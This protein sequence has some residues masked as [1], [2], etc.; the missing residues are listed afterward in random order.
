ME[1]SITVDNKIVDNNIIDNNRHVIEITSKSFN[2]EYWQDDKF[3]TCKRIGN[4]L[5]IIVNRNTD[6]YSRDFGVS[7][8]NS[9]D[10][11]DIVYIQFTQS[12]VG[13]KFIPQESS[14][15]DIEIPTDCGDNED[16]CRYTLVRGGDNS[17]KCEYAALVKMDRV[18]VNGSVMTETE[19]GLNVNLRIEGG[20]QKAFIAGIYRYRIIIDK[21]TNIEKKERMGYDGGIRAS[22]VNGDDGN[23]SVIIE[24]N[25]RPFSDND[26]YFYEIRVAHYDNS[27]YYCNIKACY[28]DKGNNEIEIK[29]LGNKELLFDYSGK[30]IGT[31]T[32]E[33][34]TG[35]SED[36]DW[37]VKEVDYSEGENGWIS[38]SYYPLNVIV[39]CK[40]NIGEERKAKII[41]YIGEEA[42]DDNL[43]EVEVTQK[44]FENYRLDADEINIEF[45]ADDTVSTA[46]FTLVCYGAPLKDIEG[47]KKV[48]PSEK[49]ADVVLQCLS[50]F[51]SG[52]VYTYM[53][54]C[55]ANTR[56]L[57]SEDV[58]TIY[59]LELDSDKP[60]L[61]KC[62]VT[63]TQKKAGT[64][65]VPVRIS[66]SEIVGEHANIN[67]I[68]NPEDSVLTA[69]SS[70][71]WCQVSSPV[72]QAGNTFMSQVDINDE[73]VYGYT[74]KCKLVFTNV[75]EPGETASCVV[76]NETGKKIKITNIKPD[77]ST[78]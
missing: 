37:G 29:G 15:K 1:Y 19:P 31:D 25:G 8:Y 51:Q 38:L 47:G 70:S 73:N 53:F 13:Y 9:C 17:E 2:F 24:N 61:P 76:E 54:S 62:V 39:K 45:M 43:V 63:V 67:L 56:N 40:E 5:K 3:T 41:F 72:P 18:Y 27:K 33:I 12:G 68:A 20:T 57:E 55:Y 6:V 78:G 64:M 28:K 7:L 35:Q 11:T 52:L 4:V 44:T 50:Y 77:S 75:N 65:L 36:C 22:V 34:I 26:E 10:K 46:T 21:E 14:N 74:R 71:Q 42:V 59:T 60:N 49:K 23:C 58:Q 30:Y 69:Y 32:I 16:D 48:V 66:G